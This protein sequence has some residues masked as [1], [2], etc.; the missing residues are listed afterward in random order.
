[1]KQPKYTYSQCEIKAKDR[2]DLCGKINRRLSRGQKLV[3][4]EAFRS[5]AG[6]RF[7]YQVTIE[8]IHQ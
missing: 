5:S 7:V 2:Y 6:S 3:C 4:Y 8:T 1:M